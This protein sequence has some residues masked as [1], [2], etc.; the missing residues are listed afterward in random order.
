[1][2]DIRERLRTSA[3]WFCEDTTEL[4]QEAADTIDRLVDVIEAF[5]S[6]DGCDWEE[7]KRRL[8]TWATLADTALASIKGSGK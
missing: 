4:A 3:F 5:P 1:M 8:R 7:A 6:F 2:T